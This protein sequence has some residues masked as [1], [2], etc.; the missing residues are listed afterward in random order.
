MSS[1][2]VPLGPRSSMG[3]EHG[4]GGPVGD[5]FCRRSFGSRAGISAILVIAM[6]LV[7]GC[8]NNS[9]GANN[10][11]GGEDTKAGER[12]TTQ[13]GDDAAGKCQTSPPT[14]LVPVV[15]RR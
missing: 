8:G 4:R 14:A 3:E 13:A 2:S 10:G 5:G 11:S 7:V 9:D 12:T 6:S 15:Q 1:G